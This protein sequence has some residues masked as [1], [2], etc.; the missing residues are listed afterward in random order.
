MSPKQIVKNRP[1][2]LFHRNYGGCAIELF[3]DLRGGE[4][5]FFFENTRS[6]SI[7]DKQPG[8]LSAIP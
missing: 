6:C 8:F 1:Y 2:S 7:F 5:Q 3:S 4:N